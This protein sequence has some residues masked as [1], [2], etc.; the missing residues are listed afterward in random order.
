MEKQRIKPKS[1]SCKRLLTAFIAAIIFA[2][3]VFSQ[4]LSTA[5]INS[6]RIKPSEGQNLYTKTDLKFELLIP[7]IKASHIQLISSSQ[8]QDITFKTMRKSEDYENGG[9]LIEIWF[10]FDKKGTYTL[11]PLQVSIQGR[12]RSLRFEPVTVE[13]DPSKQ[14][15]RIVIKFNNGTTASSDNGIFTEPL[16]NAPAGE[17]VNF[18]VYLQYASQLINFS[19]DI[20]KDA[21]LSQVKTY[22]IMEVRYREKNVS[23]SLIP[24]ASFQWTSLA[25]GKQTLPK[26]KITA[27]AYN[28]S[29]YDL[30]L[31][32]I[33]ATFTASTQTETLSQEDSMFNNAFT[34]DKD[35]DG[36]RTSVTI[37]NEICEELAQ[38]YSK[39]R[40]SI[41]KATQSR[42]AR[43]QFEMD[44]GLP[45][46][47]EKD[48]SVRIIF[49][50]ILL[51]IGAVILLLI[52]ISEK[53]SF[54][55]MI[56]II[57]IVIAVI[58]VIYGIVKRNETQGICTG[59]TIYSIPEENA[60]AKAE[61]GAGNKVYI[62]EKTGKW[63]YVELGE[64][65]GWCRAENII[66]I[67]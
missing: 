49:G 19:W 7:K 11:N 38:L 1:K 17:K 24:V 61:M 6:L 28:G 2:N 9:T 48:Y 42:K 51:L 67:K 36:T 57:L 10:T 40:N 32:E 5:D 58:I 29:R 56:A 26:M 18:T 25:K 39:E 16:F 55:I 14:A 41:L 15:P 44:N 64:T 65:G 20:P 63:C 46:N 4:S 31:P 52:S 45:V 37:T 30:V 22:E 23:H 50:A 66:I 60:E 21:I 33:P 27:T 62:T 54:R 35:T 53:K 59:C 34:Q 8:S 13:D 12:R 3:P 47:Y 43:Q